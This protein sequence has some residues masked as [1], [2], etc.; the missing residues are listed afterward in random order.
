MFGTSVKRHIQRVGV[1][2]SMVDPAQRDG[3]SGE[4][5][6]IEP[7]SQITKPFIRGFF[8]EATFAHD[9]VIGSGDVV[10]IDLLNQDFLVMNNDVE[11]LGNSALES[12][13]VLHRCNV[14]GEI[15]RASGEETRD[16]QYRLSPQFQVIASGCFALQTEP[17][18][19]GGLEEEEQLGYL[20]IEKHELYIP[21]RY[22]LDLNDRWQPT[23]GEY[24]KVVNIR[25]RRYD[26]VDVVELE[27]DNR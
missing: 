9:T 21:S 22:G 20:G 15:L 23:S 27:E 13:G 4:Y 19:G 5:V 16:N 7:N 1:V 8:K 24:Y 10:K 18:F 11:G 3:V 14:S 6:I 17:L 26:G 2:V 25:G 12:L